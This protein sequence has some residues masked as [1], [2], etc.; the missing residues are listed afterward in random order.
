MKHSFLACAHTQR[1]Q[2]T[3]RPLQEQHSITK[4]I[5]PRRD[6]KRI[7]NHLKNHEDVTSQSS[8][9]TQIM[10]L[11]LLL[12]AQVTYNQ[13]QPFQIYHLANQF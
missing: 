12:L 11:L 3:L 4:S 6:R 13:V 8:L 2:T 10:P 9:P 5:E 1:L 7:I